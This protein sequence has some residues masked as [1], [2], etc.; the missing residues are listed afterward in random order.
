MYYSFERQRGRIASRQPKT[1][2]LFTEISGQ[3]LMS[4]GAYERLRSWDKP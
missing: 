3:T 1:W 2:L 4:R